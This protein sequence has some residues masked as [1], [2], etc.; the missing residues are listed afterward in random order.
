MGPVL[1]IVVCCCLQEH[2]KGQ[3][4]SYMSRLGNEW[5][6]KETQ[7]QELLDRKL[8]NYTTMEKKLQEGI[9]QLQRQQHTLASREN[10]VGWSV[11]MTTTMA[12]QI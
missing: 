1:A 9:Q 12:Q 5:R 4:A 6:K 8:E 2:L 11:T 10:Q 3:E 7:G